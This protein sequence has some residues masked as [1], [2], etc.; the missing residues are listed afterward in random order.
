MPPTAIPRDEFHGREVLHGAELA[1]IVLDVLSLC[2]VV[3]V[4]LTISQNQSV[5]LAKAAASAAA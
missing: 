3:S 2:I 5:Y 4:H 1:E